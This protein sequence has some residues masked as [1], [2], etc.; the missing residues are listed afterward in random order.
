ML[1]NEIPNPSREIKGKNGGQTRVFS[2]YWEG[3]KST[4]YLSNSLIIL[5]YHTILR[6]MA[7][8][9]GFEPPVP[10]WG[11]YDFQSYTF[12]HSVTSP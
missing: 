12:D 11:T 5:I 3:V 10:F 6:R 7:E 9:G 8:R 2:G 4:D 1:L